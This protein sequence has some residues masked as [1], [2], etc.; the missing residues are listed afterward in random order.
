MDSVSG[1]SVVPGLSRRNAPVRRPPSSADRPTR[2]QA[3]TTLG[4]SFLG[5]YCEQ[6]GKMA[7]PIPL[8]EVVRLIRT[9]KTQKV[10]RG[11]KDGGQLGFLRTRVAEVLDAESQATGSDRQ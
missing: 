1:D 11:Y 2:H 6:G 8:A 3:E 10:W 5:W 4:F 9:G 7:G